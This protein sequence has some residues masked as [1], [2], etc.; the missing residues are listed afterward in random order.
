MRATAL[1]DGDAGYAGW[2]LFS[3][4]QTGG[5]AT[6]TAR[7]S[8]DSRKQNYSSE[9]TFSLIDTLASAGAASR[10]AR[11]DADSNS[12]TAHYIGQHRSAGCWQQQTRLRTRRETA[13]RK[14]LF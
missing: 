8:V 1:S 14:C 2:L 13:L 4:E 5:K 6:Q 7:R 11:K 3:K 10:L 12:V 9:W